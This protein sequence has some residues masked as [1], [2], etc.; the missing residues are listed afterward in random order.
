MPEVMNGELKTKKL[1][2]ISNKIRNMFEFDYA[3]AKEKE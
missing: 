1:Q 3:K 2:N